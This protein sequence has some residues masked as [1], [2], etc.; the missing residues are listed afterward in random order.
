MGFLAFPC[1]GQVLKNPVQKTIQKYVLEEKI[2][3][4]KLWCENYQ[5]RSW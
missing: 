1:Y 3:E 5:T 4:F 2:N